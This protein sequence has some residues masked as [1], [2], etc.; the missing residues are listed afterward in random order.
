[1]KNFSIALIL[2]YIYYAIL[3]VMHPNNI[4]VPVLVLLYFGI[5]LMH[6][7]TYKVVVLVSSL[8]VALLYY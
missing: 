7:S 8:V 4:L 5:A 2:S 3:T 1:M 6:H